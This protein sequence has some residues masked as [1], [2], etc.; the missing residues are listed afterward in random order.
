VAGSTGFDTLLPL[1][2]AMSSDSSPFRV[3]SKSATTSLGIGG[4]AAS[5]VGTQDSYK[6]DINAD[7]WRAIGPLHTLE[8]SLNGKTMVN[9]SQNQ[10]ALEQATTRLLIAKTSGMQRSR[11]EGDR[12][13]QPRTKCTQVGQK[14]MVKRN[15]ERNARKQVRNA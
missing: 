14:Q 5:S 1:E 6:K 3:G 8:A 13:S 15:Q 2:S 4:I 11:A 9:C 10:K 7:C 12:Q